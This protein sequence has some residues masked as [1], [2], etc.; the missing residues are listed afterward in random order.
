M[1]YGIYC[2]DPAVDETE[3]AGESSTERIVPLVPRRR[4]RHRCSAPGYGGGLYRL[5]G[6]PLA[7]PAI[8]GDTINAAVAIAGRDPANKRAMQQ[9]TR[10]VGS[11]IMI[12]SMADLQ[13][14]LRA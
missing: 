10:M 4:Q 1:S 8:I 2:E 11:E 6:P 13:V 12:E 9:T 14:P 7:A 5:S 3:S